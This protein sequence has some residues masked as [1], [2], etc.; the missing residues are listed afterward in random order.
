MM[1]E[2]VTLLFGP[3]AC[4][5]GWSLTENFNDPSWFDLFA[6][7]T[8]GMLVSCAVTEELLIV[9]RKQQNKTLDA[10]VSIGRD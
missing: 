9:T 7:A 4:F 6:L 1:F 8:S 3:S 5:A 10:T 2:M